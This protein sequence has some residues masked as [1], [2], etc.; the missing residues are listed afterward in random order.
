[1]QQ[2]SKLWSVLVLGP[3]LLAP[4]LAVEFPRV[5]AYLPL[6]SLVFGSAILWRT[7]T[8][9]TVPKRATAILISVVAFLALSAFVISPSEDAM[10]R[11]EKLLMLLVLGSLFLWVLFLG[12]G[13]TSKKVT[14]WLMVSCSIG[15]TLTCFEVL[16]DAMLYEL[17]RPDVTKDEYGMAVFNRGALV[18]TLLSLL[19][20]FVERGTRHKAFYLLFLP[21]IG[22][23]FLVE[24]QSSQ[25]TAIA[26]L[27]F[28]FFFPVNH[29]WAWA[30]FFVLLSIGALSKPFLVQSA[31]QNLPE[32]I[33]D[34]PLLQQAYV[35]HR[36]EIWDFIA[37]KALEEPF[38]G[39]GLEY[40]RN[41]ET[42]ETEAR[43]LASNSILHPHSAL[44]QMW[45][46]LGIIGV[47]VFLGVSA[48][49]I[50][51]IFSSSDAVTRKAAI[52]LFAVSVLVSC[53]SYGMWQS[54]WIGL[55]FIIS[56]IMLSI[57]PSK[58]HKA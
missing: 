29:K 1:M 57:L 28:F 6:A 31:Y 58:E 12:R 22:M 30:V 24:S 23:L 37:R 35:G 41:C 49:L 15:A 43:F 26:G 19:V 36:I 45:I 38:F 5:L 53:F 46:E 2:Y 33:H 54:W 16:S 11:F 20:L 51:S 9:F 39:H 17:I 18:I 8:A 3:L 21:V 50:C 25:I 55:L 40:T 14:R 13:F 4:V 32:N 52:S 44:L 42:F 10:E 27:I 47:L 7:K 34:T 48:V 56:A